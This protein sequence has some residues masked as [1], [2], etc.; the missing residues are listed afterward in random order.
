MPRHSE[1]LG[2]RNGLEQIDT[3]AHRILKEKIIGKLSVLPKRFH[4]FCIISIIYIYIIFLEGRQVNYI[5]YLKEQIRVTME[6]I[7]Q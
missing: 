3:A 6:T 1:T 4:E 2:Q 7:K 5:L